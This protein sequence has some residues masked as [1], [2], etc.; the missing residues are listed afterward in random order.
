MKLPWSQRFVYPIRLRPGLHYEIN[1]N[2]VRLLSGD[3]G[4]LLNANT[5]GR[6]EEHKAFSGWESLQHWVY[7]SWDTRESMQKVKACRK[8]ALLLT[9]RGKGGGK[10]QNSCSMVAIIIKR[11]TPFTNLWHFSK[12]LQGKKKARIK[13]FISS[14]YVL[15]TSY[16]TTTFSF[17]QIYGN[18]HW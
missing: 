4:W 16:S 1:C 12:C 15:L 2:H 3:A 14:Y 9:V 6:G 5:R 18:N 11:Q 17:I 7:S 10:I 13:P 8:P